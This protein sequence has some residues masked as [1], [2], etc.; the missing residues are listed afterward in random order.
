MTH[1]TKSAD[2]PVFRNVNGA[3]TSINADLTSEHD[4]APSIVSSV[5]V[6]LLYKATSQASSRTCNDRPAI[7]VAWNIIFWASQDWI[8]DPGSP[9]IR[10]KGST[11]ALR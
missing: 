10:A 6:W 8:S 3:L 11:R 2:D 5:R 9:L 1:S 7:H 4:Q